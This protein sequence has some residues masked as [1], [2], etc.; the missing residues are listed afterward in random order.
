MSENRFYI[1][2]DVVALK[3][4]CSGYVIDGSVYPIKGLR[5]T[6]CRCATVLL[7]V[8]ANGNSDTISCPR[9]NVTIKNSENIWWLHCDN[10]A[11]LDSLCNIEEL[12]EVLT[13]PL[14]EVKPISK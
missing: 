13:E 11:P 3:D 8:G 1:G 4:M 9:C 12:T 2:Q 7:D 10:F 6:F 5:A 14:F